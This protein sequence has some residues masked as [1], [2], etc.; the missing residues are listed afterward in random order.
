LAQ[1]AQSIISGATSSTVDINSLVQSMVT[2]K[3]AAQA[4]AI[5]NKQTSDNTELTAIG[6]IKSALSSLDDALS[7]F[8]DGTAL[9]QMTASMSGTGITA[10][11][12][13]GATAGTYSISVSNVATASTATSTAVSSTAPLSA[14]TITIQAGSASALNISV[15]S[16]ESLTDLAASINKAPGNASVS[17]TVV[18]ASDGQHLILTSKQTGQANSITLTSDVTAGSTA[19]FSSSSVVAGTDAQLSINGLSVTSAS[20]TV[21]NAL[22]GVT[23]NIANVSGASPTTP[24]TQTLTIGV[25]NSASTTAINN[26]VTAYNNYVT[27]ASGLTSYDASTSTAG[28]LLG[29]SMTNGITNG[30]ATLISNGIQSGGTTYSLA[31]IGLNLQ[32]DGT[33]SVDN[34]ALQNALTS[35]S[36]AVSAVFNTANGIGAKLDLFMSSYIQSS[37]VISQRTDMLN[38]D[39]SNLQDQSNQLTDYQ[40]TLTAQYNAQFSALDTLMAQMQ[41]NS[42]YLTQ[43]FGG[44]KGSSGTMSSNS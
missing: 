17:A 34:T 18:S 3:T 20:N 30:L 39:L 24:V 38:Q 43:L 36:T 33:I 29:D 13:S 10:T 26:F 15:T 16:G 35:N 32:P 25:D 5:S 4:T 8:L 19:L 12:A 28:P 2:A 22:T 14:G 42:Q 41:S 27:T 7:G 1:A 11:T 37:G 31:S 9:S 23:L 44:N 40:N 6:K 21:S